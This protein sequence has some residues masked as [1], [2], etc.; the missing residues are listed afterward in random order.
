MSSGLEPSMTFETRSFGGGLFRNR[1]VLMPFAA[2]LALWMTVYGVAA[3]RYI[4]VAIKQ[5]ADVL[6]SVVSVTSPQQ[7]SPS[8]ND[9]VLELQAK[10]RLPVGG[11][12]LR[13]EATEGAQWVEI[14]AEPLQLPEGLSRLSIA[15]PIRE[16]PMREAVSVTVSVRPM[17]PE[18]I[19]VLPRE[20]LKLTIA[21]RP[22]E[23]KSLPSIGAKSHDGTFH[24]QES[25]TLLPIVVNITSPELLE[26]TEQVVRQTVSW[27]GNRSDKPARLR[28]LHNGPKW[29][30]PPSQEVELTEGMR[31]KNVTWNLISRPFGTEVLVAF[32]ASASRVAPITPWHVKLQPL[33]TSESKPQPLLIVIDT[34]QLA[35]AKAP[36]FAPL[37]RNLITSRR[38]QLRGG[39]AIVL[40]KEGLPE[41]CTAVTTFGKADA[42]SG[43]TAN[44]AM[45]QLADLLKQDDNSS[46]PVI[47][48]WANGFAP[49]ADV[50]NPFP[51]SRR[52]T[53]NLL[54]LN[55]Q[56]ADE[57]GLFEAWDAGDTADNFQIHIL[58]APENYLKTSLDHLLTLGNRQEQHGTE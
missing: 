40:R 28:I 57:K 43:P 9:I 45:S 3:H 49:P 33:L 13:I 42:H 52:R 32:E 36:W 20:P 46:G 51:L 8:E 44:L 4:V 29:L 16:R 23:P 11:T 38:D 41:L 2:W 48:I 54:W 53:M 7:G 17:T 58:Y 19:L 34:T 24:N 18:T 6:K 1:A 47:V 12:E 30:M 21:P 5:Q 56:N 31:E 39:S 22:Y 14:P 37:Y 25:A 27:T 10:T 35:E 15:I 55:V 26:A 50:G